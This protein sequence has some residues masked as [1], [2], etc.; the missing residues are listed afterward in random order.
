MKPVF[1]VSVN[2]ATMMPRRSLLGLA[3]LGL[4]IMGCRTT[5]PANGHAVDSLAGRLEGVWQF[6]SH[7][8]H[9]DGS[10]KSGHLHGLKFMSNGHFGLVFYKPEDSKFVGTIVGT[11]VALPDNRHYRENYRLFNFG[12]DTEAHSIVFLARFSTDAYE[13]VA[14]GIYGYDEAFAR[15]S[16]GEGVP[17]WSGTWRLDVQ[18]PVQTWPQAAAGTRIIIGDRF[19]DAWGVDTF[20]FLGLRTGR[21]ARSPDGKVTLTTDIQSWEGDRTPEVVVAQKSLAAGA[22]EL[23]CSDGVARRLVREPPHTEV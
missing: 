4:S 5:S 19:L 9:A 14:E 16:T 11:Y 10:S 15:A 20:S 23:Q 2:A 3:S 13:H 6:R 22:L 18:R 17:G 8:R 7:T 21:I 1:P 12:R